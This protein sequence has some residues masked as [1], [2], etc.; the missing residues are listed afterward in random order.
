M[1]VCVCV[2]VLCLALGERA[3]PLGGRNVDVLFATYLFQ[4]SDKHVFSKTTNDDN[5]KEQKDD[6]QGKDG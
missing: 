1:Y 5:T 4:N 3:A 6:G 2:C